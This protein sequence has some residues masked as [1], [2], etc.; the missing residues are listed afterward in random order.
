MHVVA[1]ALEIESSHFLRKKIIFGKGSADPLQKPLVAC[2]TRIN[3]I[4]PSSWNS[5]P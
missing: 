5:V 2:D 4:V 3:V 1:K